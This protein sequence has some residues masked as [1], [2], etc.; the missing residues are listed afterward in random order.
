MECQTEVHSDPKDRNGLPLSFL[1]YMKR[2]KS[3]INSAFAQLFLNAQQT[4]IFGD[5]LASAG[6]PRLNLAGIQ[7]YSQIRNRSILRFPER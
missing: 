5:T 2:V 1:S 4:V 7:R 3:R 6:R